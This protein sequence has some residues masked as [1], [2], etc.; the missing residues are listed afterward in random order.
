MPKL[1]L[2]FS[3]GG[4]YV[5]YYYGV[6]QYLHE[7][8]DLSAVSYFSGISAG[9]QVA[10]W[11]A[12]GV[13][14]TTAW[15]EWF[16]PTFRRGCVNTNTFGT[17]YYPD[18]RKT[19][20]QNLLPLYD[21]SMLGA[22]N[23]S[24][25]IGVTTLGTMQKKT[26]HEF[27]NEG[28]LFDSLLASQCVPFLFDNYVTIRGVNYVDGVITHTP[29]YEPCDANWVHISIFNWE[30]LHVLGSFTSL[31]YLHSM[32]HHKYMKNLGYAAAKRRYKWFLSKGLTNRPKSYSRA[33]SQ[34]LRNGM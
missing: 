28:E 5:G 9:C 29:N 12:C 6:F 31:R 24:L 20:M 26:L 19:A 15:N 8:F 23:R 16:I 27:L 2:S 17:P 33:R 11:M 1:G 21:H 10:Y 13:S 18:L 34:M 3:Y 7:T 30:P 14:P 32:S 4:A 25:Y 22:C